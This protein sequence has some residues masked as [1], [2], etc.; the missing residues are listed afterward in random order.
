MIVKKFNQ[1]LNESNS[2][3]MDP[4][5]AEILS[6]MITKNVPMEEIKE[7]SYELETLSRVSESVNENF[8]SNIYDKLKS[9][10]QR[11]FDDKIW[12]Y[13]I[14]RKKD[15]YLSLIDE[16]KIFDLTTLDDVIASR[17]GFKL[18][19]MY[20][21]GGMDKAKDVGAGWRHTLEYEFDVVNKCDSPN[22]NLEPVDL[23]EY[24]EID[25]CRIV[26]D[27]HLVE[28]LAN[29]SKVKSQYAKP[30]LLNPVRKEV[31]RQKSKDFADAIVKYKE[32]THETEPEEYEPTMTNLRKTMNSSIEVDD[33]HLVR[34]SDAIFLG[35]NTTAGSGT[36]GE[37][38]MQSFLN[39]PVF[40]WMTDKEWNLSDFSVWSFPHFSKFARNE[41]EMKILVKTLA[42]YAK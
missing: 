15:F 24:G 12:N 41:E 40:V 6:A 30:L 18:E 42:N 14:N 27:Y 3:E 36:F 34:I 17:P 26:D 1:Y 35:L 19:S 4:A 33:E 28:F 37:L 20:L 32:F 38:Q 9:K 13:I 5:I 22:S 23:G 29:P 7:F 31:D 39:K 11:W 10:F 21:A 16:L 25:A 8:L 2:N